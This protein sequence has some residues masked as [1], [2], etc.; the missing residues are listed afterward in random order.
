[1]ITTRFLTKFEYIQ[2]ADWVKKLDNETRGTYFG[3]QYTDEQIDKLVERIIEHS[4]KHHFLVAEYKNEWIGTIH[5]GE[6]NS[7]EVEFGFIVDS[8]HRGNGIA[9]RMMKEAIVWARNRGYSSLYMHCLPYNTPIKRLCIKN[10]MELHTEYGETDTK[11]E[12]D[13]PD[14]NSLTE[15]VATRNRQAYRMMLQTFNPL[16]KEIYA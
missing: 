15:E 16:L 1:M 6:V 8:E 12:L 9:D 4:D 3:V 7:A 10:G 13:P 5:I 11:L 14:L 2:Y